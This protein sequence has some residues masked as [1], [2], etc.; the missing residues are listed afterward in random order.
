V[1]DWFPS[2]LEVRSGKTELFMRFQRRSYNAFSPLRPSRRR[3]SGLHHDSRNIC[4]KLAAIARRARTF[5]LRPNPPRQCN[6]FGCGNGP[7]HRPMA[8]DGSASFGGL[9]LARAWGVATDQICRASASGIDL[10]SR[11][12]SWPGLPLRVYASREL[13]TT[14]GYANTLRAS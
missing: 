2:T 4:G 3:L 5:A 7:M 10:D 1:A 6:A 14:R 9:R 13:Q 11:R 8:W 12:R